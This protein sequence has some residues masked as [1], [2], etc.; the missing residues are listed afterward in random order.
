[1]GEG[2]A[3]VSE[4]ID[5]EAVE[6]REVPCRTPASRLSYGILSPSCS[7]PTIHRL[8]ARLRSSTSDT[9]PLWPMQGSRSRGVRPSCSTRHSIA[10]TG[11]A[12]PKSS[13]SFS[14]A[15]IGVTSTS[16]SSA[17]G[18]PSSAWKTPLPPEGALEVVVV[19][20]RLTRSLPRVLADDLGMW[21]TVVKAS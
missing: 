14:Q 3:I 5:G 10:A 20:D 15:S 6:S 11:S 17:C 9:R 12:G 4:A 1:M 16:R 8:G 18:V 7:R 21:V 2:P 13:C 19:A